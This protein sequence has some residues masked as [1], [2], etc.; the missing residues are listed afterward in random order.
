ML[1]PSLDTFFVFLYDYYFVLCKWSESSLR[2]LEAIPVER[3]DTFQ[4]IALT[5]C[6]E[7]SQKR[8]VILRMIQER[9]TEEEV[10]REIDEEDRNLRNLLGNSSVQ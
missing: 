5:Y 3:S 6:K 10:T 8:D 7:W 2:F 1:H 9:K 4:H